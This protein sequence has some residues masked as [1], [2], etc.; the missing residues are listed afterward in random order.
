MMT[1]EQRWRDAIAKGELSP[2]ER[3]ALRAHLAAHPEE[4]ADWEAELA[5]SRA[6]RDLPDVPVAS[7]FNARVLAQLSVPERRARRFTLPD[8]LLRP[9]WSL[10]LGLAMCLVL[11][12]WLGFHQVQTRQVASTLATVSQVSPVPSPEILQDFEAIRL[13]TPTPGADDELLAIL[14]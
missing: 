12:G 2:A 4:R 8:W 10:R 9:A 6:L 7:N 5:L 1:N 13:M 11:T 3:E 14:Q